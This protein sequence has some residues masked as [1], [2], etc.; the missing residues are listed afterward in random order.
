MVVIGWDKRGRLVE[1]GA[2]REV[3]GRFVIGDVAYASLMACG[4]GLGGAK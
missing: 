4:A 1:R 3:E 2:S